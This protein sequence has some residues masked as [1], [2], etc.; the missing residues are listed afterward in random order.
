MLRISIQIENEIHESVLQGVHSSTNESRYCHLFGI[1]AIS[2][3]EIISKKIDFACF[4]LLFL[5]WES[6]DFVKKKISR[7]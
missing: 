2:S 4:L 5:H 3:H 6:Y 7:Y 1:T